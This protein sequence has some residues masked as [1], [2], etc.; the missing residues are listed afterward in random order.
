VQD[1]FWESLSRGTDMGYLINKL[2]NLPIDKSVNFYIFVINGRYIDSLHKI[3]ET[4]FASIAKGI[5]DHAVIAMGTDS[6]K[7]STSVARKYLGEGNSDSSFTQM[8]PALLI[9]DSLG[10]SF[11]CNTQRPQGI[12]CCDGQTKQAPQQRGTWRDFGGA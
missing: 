5:G 10:S 11:K 1:A 7:F 9:T 6:E 3:I 8:I 12:G 4:N 2:A